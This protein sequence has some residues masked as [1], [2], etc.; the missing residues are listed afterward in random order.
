MNKRIA[1]QREKTGI[2]GHTR[3]AG[4]VG[5]PIGHTLSPAMQNAAFRHHGLNVAYLPLG[6]SPAGLAAFCRGLRP[7]EPAGLNITVPHK[8]AVIPLLDG[9][10]ASASVMGAVNTV[11]CRA[12]RW[13]GHNTDGF[14]FLA[15][16]KGILAPQGLQV[17]LLGGGGAGRAV[18]FSLAQAGAAR[19]TLVEPDSGRRNRLIRDLKQ[20]LGY[21]AVVAARPGTAELRS[22]LDRCALL[23]Q[24]T[25]LGLQARDP[26]P[27]P[28]PWMPEGICVY[29]LVY[30]RQLTPFLRLAKRRRNRV[31]PGWK[32]LLGQGAEAFRLWTGKQPPV[33]LM[34]EALLSAGGLKEI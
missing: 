32:M 27:L 34:Q 13:I 7:L 5:W 1:S 22:A 18:A 25:P 33:K 21:S 8:E 28:E 3:L 2:N 30:G 12:G 29:D 9:L 26:L 14:G 19:I 20:R 15:S 31:V 4:V 11:V 6:V 10:A 23:V 16:L 17:V 24:A